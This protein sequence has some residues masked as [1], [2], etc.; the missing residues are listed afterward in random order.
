MDLYQQI[1]LVICILAY[2]II[3]AKFIPPKYHFIS[4]L[5]AASTALYWALL[6]GFTPDD[7]GIGFGFILSGVLVAIGASVIILSA[8]YV[9]TFI[10]FIKRILLNHNSILQSKP[11]KIAYETTVRIPLS[12]ALSEEIL[13]RGVLLGVFLSIYPTIEAVIITSIVFGFWH[14]FP[15]LNTMNENYYKK[16]TSRSKKILSVLANIATTTI[17]G[18]FFSWLRILSNS[19]LAPWLVHWTINS[20]S[21]LSVIFASKK[22]SHKP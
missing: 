19:I 20:S 10:P 4:N 12:T 5:L 9:V 3:L 18:I 1:L 14:I 11:T 15:A 8:A 6:S 16:N 13:F 22:N 17:A 2:G 21:V 7:L